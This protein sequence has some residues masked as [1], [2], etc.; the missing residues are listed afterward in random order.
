MRFGYSLDQFTEIDMA[1]VIFRLFNKNNV[2]IIAR[3]F[4]CKIRFYKNLF[5][6]AFAVDSNFI[7]IDH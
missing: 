6:S 5:S 7:F 3:A 1:Q 4:K 2:N